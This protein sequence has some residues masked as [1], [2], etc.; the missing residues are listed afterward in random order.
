MGHIDVRFADKNS[1]RYM[2][3]KRV[4]KIIEILESD[5]LYPDSEPLSGFSFRDGQYKISQIDEGEWK[6]FDSEKDY[7][8]YPECYAWFRHSFKIPERFAGKPVLYEVMPSAQGPWRQVNP[9][10]IFYFNGKLTQGGDSNHREVRLLEC[11]NGGEEFDCCINAHTDAWEFKGPV[12]MRAR[13]VVID[14]LVK[15][16]IFDLKTPLLVASRYTV[17]DIPRI[18]IV[19]A[20]TDA[21][22]LIDFN[23]TDYDKFAASANAAIELLEKE[24]Y[25]KEAMDAMACCIGHTHIDVAWLWRL[26]QTREKAGRSFATVLKLMEEYPE[27][28][29]MSSQA[30]LYDFVKQDYPEVY[31]GIKKMVAAGRWEVEGSMWVESDT[32]VTSGESLVRQFLIGKRFFKDEFGVDNKIMWLPDVFGYSAALPQIMK[33]AGI[34]YFMTTKISWNEFNKV[35]YDTFM[36]KGIDG[37]EILSHFSP[38]TDCTDESDRWQTTYNAYLSPPE[39]MGGWQRYSQK[40]LNR[41]YLCTFGHGDGGGG[42]TRDMLEYG[43]RME[44]GIPGCP[45]IKQEF[46]IDFYRDLEKDV[47]GSRRLPKWAGELYL[48]FHRG[49][50]TSQSRNKRYNRKSELLYHDIETL[51][52]I[53]DHR[54][55]AEYPKEQINEG[56][57]IILLNQFHDIIPGSSIK[58]VYDDS[59]EQY[60]KL[61]EEGRAL[62][63]ETVKKIAGSIADNANSLIVFNTYGAKRSDVVITDMPVSDSFSIL[64]ADGSKLAWQRTADGKLAFFAKD[65]PAKGFKVFRIADGAKPT[66]EP[67]KVENLRVENRFFSVAFDKDMNISSLL[68]KES[69][70]TVAPEGEVLN[71]LIAYTDQPFNHE[72]WD[73]KAYFDQQYTEINDVSGIEVVENGPVRAVIK[74]T[75]KFL[76]STI[77]QNFIFYADLDRIDIDYKVDWKE[78][79]ILLKADFPVDV[80]AT[81]ATY[82]IQFGNYRRSTTRNTLWDFAQFEVSG[83]KWVDLSDNGFGLSV[84]NDCKYGHDIKDGHIRTSLL[85]CANNPNWAQ[86]REMH[87]FTYALYPHAGTVE[88]SNVVNHGYSLNLPLYCAK[89]TADHG[90]YSFVS[91]DKDNIIIETVKRAEDSN[92]IVIRAYETWNKKTACSYKFAEA[93]KSVYICNL[94]EENE[95]EVPVNGDEINLEFKPFEIKTIK[96]SF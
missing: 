2:L 12:R 5:Y 18:D 69:G 39:I 6:P 52:A 34:D 19:K 55:L 89:S 4:Y 47:I 62:A 86:D 73:I 15:R 10:L 23:T 8:G 43:R 72:A 60:D 36:W 16:L 74:V 76:A 53:A 54:G 79:N 87:Y 37:T 45:K 83:H 84:L 46:S 64:D 32:N 67:I 78:K 49:T 94:L 21:V 42:P 58:E 68:H 70:R 27:Y 93:P 82:D 20:L 71:K 28:K 59:K 26:R 77:E 31:E 92:D 30:Q 85:R 96:V 14:D 56:W 65:V 11:A 29:F 38:S 66:D 88:N 51:C 57:K 13:L 95:E 44:K 1:E 24:I 25:S 9:Q 17:D 81:S 91:A 75:R 40:D 48:E 33:K 90:S 22:N 80:N 3:A 35:P 50:L 41:E 63:G 7:W 61:L